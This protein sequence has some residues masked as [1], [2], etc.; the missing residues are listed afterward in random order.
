MTGV[1]QG[2]YWYSAKRLMAC[3]R[4]LSG[5][6][7]LGVAQNGM[8]TMSAQDAYYMQSALRPPAKN[9]AVQAA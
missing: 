1:P 9:T 4:A 3:L 6:V 5:T 8:L 7:T 2:E